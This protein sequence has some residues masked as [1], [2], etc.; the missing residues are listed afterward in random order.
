MEVT[1]RHSLKALNNIEVEEGSRIRDVINDFGPA[2][3]LPENVRAVINGET[4]DQDYLLQP[5]DIV[6]FEKRAAD[7]AA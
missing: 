6:T 1:L 4:V 7:K 2:L 3:R 5:G